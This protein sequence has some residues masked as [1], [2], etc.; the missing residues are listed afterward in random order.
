MMLA[1]ETAILKP[2]ALS[3]RR[4]MRR[5]DAGNGKL[6]GIVGAGFSGI[7][8]AIHLR[9]ALP[10]N[11]VVVLFDRTGRFARGPAY[12]EM[13]APHLLNVRSANMNALPDDPGH[14]ER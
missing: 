8:A 3:T 2:A 5:G 7:T 13:R 1:S 9:R 11:W 10:P 12:S 4:R 14:F 6:V